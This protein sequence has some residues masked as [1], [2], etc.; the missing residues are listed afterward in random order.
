MGPKVLL[1]RETD[2]ESGS[3]SRT[4]RRRK[5]L[6]QSARPREQVDY[7]YSSFFQ[8]GT[9][10]TRASLILSSR[11]ASRGKGHWASKPVLTSGGLSTGFKPLEYVL[12]SYAAGRKIPARRHYAAMPD[13]IA[14]IVQR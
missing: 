5:A 2:P 8:R 11:S 10:Q 3:R 9:H 12:L 14:D 13:P 1:D 6:S 4:A 7:R